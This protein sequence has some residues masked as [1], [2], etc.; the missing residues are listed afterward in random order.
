VDNRDQVLRVEGTLTSMTLEPYEFRD[1]EEL[2]RDVATLVDLVEDRAFVALVHLPATEQRVVEVREL[3]LP[4][5]LDDDDDISDHLCGVAR[6]FD[7]PQAAPSPR[8]ALVTVLVR[9]GRC[10]F[11]P[12]EGVWLRGWRYSNHHTRAYDSDLILVTEHGWTDFMT[13]WSGHEPSLVDRPAS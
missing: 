3:D 8:H 13:E 7:I 12:N 6:S 2:I 5:L 10:V 9:R 1:P 11:G 4:A